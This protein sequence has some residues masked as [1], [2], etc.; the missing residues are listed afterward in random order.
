MKTL[1]PTVSK[2][3]CLYKKYITN[4]ILKNSDIIY[5]FIFLQSSRQSFLYVI[6]SLKINFSEIEAKFIQDRI[7][8]VERNLGEFCNI[9]AQY[10]RKTARLRD[11]GDDLAKIILNYAESENIN[12][13]LAMGLESFAESL[14]TVSDY[15]ESRVQMLDTKVI[16]EFAR[17][18]DICKHVKDEVKDIYTA[19]DRE[20][21]KK[22]QLDR[23]KERN[24]RNRQQIVSIVN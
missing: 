1:T 14:S 24:P 12:K 3:K 23:I 21:N 7:Q 19:R 10:C 2:D 18:E 11:K 15:G 9:F 13:S 20:M 8:F 5:L 22:R 4:T 6:I 16:N 17:Y